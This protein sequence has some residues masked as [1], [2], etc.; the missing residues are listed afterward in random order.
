MKVNYKHYI[1]ITIALV[2]LVV[3]AASYLLLYRQVVS[4]ARESSQALAEFTLEN[5]KKLVERELTALYA[6]SLNAR[7]RIN[8]FI[9]PEEKIVGLIEAIEK[10]GENSATDLEISAINTE[11][12]KEDETNGLTH[13]NA[14]LAVK[15]SWINIMRA[16]ILIENLPYSLEINNLKLSTLG[17]D[18]IAPSKKGASVKSWGMSMTIRV[19][20]KQTI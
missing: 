12:P 10:A 4:Q 6:D 8:S 18:L 16:L 14:T 11:K 1:L 5:N 20:A 3:S 19:L 13:I 15:G 7:A 2:A 9:V 17:D